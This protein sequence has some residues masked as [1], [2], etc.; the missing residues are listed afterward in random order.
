MFNYIT[1]DGYN[2]AI[3]QQTYIRRWSRAFTSQLAANIVRLNFVDRG[4][5]LFVWSF[6]IY[7]NDWSNSADLSSIIPQ[8]VDEQMANLE[9]SYLKKATLL[10]FTDP[11]NN[12]YQIYFTNLNQIIPPYATIGKIY[13]SYEVEL[14]TAAG[15]TI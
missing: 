12:I 3:A 8:T 13:V 10:N 5:G 14:T 6:T 15:P 11:F 9:A 1:L 7:A 4:P 2:Y